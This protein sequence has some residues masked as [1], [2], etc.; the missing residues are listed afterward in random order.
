MNLDD[1]GRTLLE[2]LVSKL[3]KAKPGRPETFIGYKEC[4][5]QL[6]LPKLREKWG[7]SLKQ[8][9]LSSLA[10]W[11]ESNDKPGI[12]GLIIN[13]STMEPGKGFFNLFGKDDGDYLW[14]SEQ[15]S[16]SKEYNWSPYLSKVFDL[17]PCDLDI[18]ER[19]DITTSR[20]I[21]DS[22]LSLKVKILHSYKC[23]LCGTAL[24]M[25]E[26]KLYAEAHHIK[27]LGSPHSGPD[28]IENMICLCP[29]HHAMLD[30]GAIKL[31][32]GTLRVV[33]GHQVSE[34]YITYHNEFVYKP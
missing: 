10:N 34:D 22:S 28:V 15:I 1:Q 21:R 27:P 29:N 11:T 17:K 5:T 23:Q 9:G 14:W 32:R 16:K 26:G 20:I 3:D 18:P 25:P 6:G 7:E 8:Q 12:T 2:L 24:D 31:D 13:L 30:Y 33:E 4:H 19:E